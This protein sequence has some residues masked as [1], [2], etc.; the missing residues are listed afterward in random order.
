V[1]GPSPVMTMKVIDRIDAQFKPHGAKALMT[2]SSNY[3][4][5]KPVISLQTR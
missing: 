1:A 2:A 3:R 4:S 5:G